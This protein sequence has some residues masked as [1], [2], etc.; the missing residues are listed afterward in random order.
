MI[1]EPVQLKTKIRQSRQSGFLHGYSL[2][3]FHGNEEGVPGNW[4]VQ[5]HPKLNASAQKVST[6]D[7]GLPH[8]CYAG[9]E[10]GYRQF[11]VPRGETPGIILSLDFIPRASRGFKCTLQLRLKK[12]RERIPSWMWPGLDASHSIYFSCA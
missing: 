8:Y 1:L 11:S 9:Q 3:C 4:L 6:S 2:G 5:V 10:D 7:P 12:K